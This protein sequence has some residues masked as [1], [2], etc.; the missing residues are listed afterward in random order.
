MNESVNMVLFKVLYPVDS[1][2]TSPLFFLVLVLEGDFTIRYVISDV[3]SPRTQLKADS[4]NF[5]IKARIGLVSLHPWDTEVV[6][7]LPE[8]D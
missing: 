6:S 1:S 4:G 8:T 2:H 3:L 5:H 7:N